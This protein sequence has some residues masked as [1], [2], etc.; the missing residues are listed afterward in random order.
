MIIIPII[1][2]K[3]QNTEITT[4]V[5]ISIIKGNYQRAIARSDIHCTIKYFIHRT[6]R[7]PTAGQRT[8]SNFIDK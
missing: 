3:I 6:S 8:L 4:I 2:M 1:L 5:G 7:Y